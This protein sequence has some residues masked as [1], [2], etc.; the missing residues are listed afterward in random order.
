MK[1]INEYLTI[2]QTAEKMGISII[3]LRKW[4]KMGKIKSTIHPVNGFFLY[5]PEDIDEIL[6]KLEP[7]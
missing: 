6:K 4:T 3:T 5:L 2:S 7:K 1:K